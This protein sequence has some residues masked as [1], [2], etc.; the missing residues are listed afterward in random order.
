MTDR[1]LSNQ[2]TS[3]RSTVRRVYIALVPHRRVINASV[4]ALVWTTS[5]VLA[6]ALRYDFSFSRVTWSGLLL[7]VPLAVICQFIFG[8]A[9]GLYLG[10]WSFGPFEEVASL[11]RTVLATGTVVFITNQLADRG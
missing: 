8:L 5:L 11:S 7:I 9:D 6:T 10:R 1:D 4:D 3:L 2:S